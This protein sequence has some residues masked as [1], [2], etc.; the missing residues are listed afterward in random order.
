MRIL[1]TLFFFGILIT[2]VHAQELN[3]NN[4]ISHLDNLI[5]SEK[6]S[7]ERD[8]KTGQ[9]KLYPMYYRNFDKQKKYDPAADYLINNFEVV[10]KDK[11]LTRKYDKLIQMDNFHFAFYLY[12]KAVE[13]KKVDLKKLMNYYP[14]DIILL[15]SSSKYYRVPKNREMEL[16]PLSFRDF[17]LLHNYTMAP[18][19]H[20]IDKFRTHKFTRGQHIHYNDLNKAKPRR[21]SLRWNVKVATVKAMKKLKPYVGTV[22]SGQRTPKD[23]D[24]KILKGDILCYGGFLST[25]LDE[26]TGEYYRKQAKSKYLFKIES[27]TGVSIY[28]MSNFRTEG[29]ILF[30]PYKKFKL[31]KITKVKDDDPSNFGTPSFEEFELGVKIIHLEEV[32]DY[33]GRCKSLSSGR[34]LNPKQYFGN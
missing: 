13:S 25:S 16:S 22:W 33:K 28:P 34:R 23:L 20:F 19:T 10:G 27:K 7:Y 12:S 9:F 4:I 29:E 8:I 32:K 3:K 31:V 18:R 17:F 24:K 21:G 5:E 6:N 1:T 26:A 15:N 14:I 2:N 11:R 30:Y